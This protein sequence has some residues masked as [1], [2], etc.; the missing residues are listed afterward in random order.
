MFSSLLLATFSV[1]F[2]NEKTKVIFLI[3]SIF[4]TSY[5]LCFRNH[6]GM[7]DGEYMYIF[8]NAKDMRLLDYL[9]Y[10]DIEIGYKIIN[11]I[12]CKLTNNY[13]ICQFIFAFVPVALIEI[14]LWQKREYIDFPIALLYVYMT[15]YY[16]IFAAGLVRIFVSVSIFFYALDYL[17]SGNKAKYTLYVIIASLFHRSVLIMLI[18]L[19]LCVNNNYFWKRIMQFS[20]LLVVS[21]P[22]IMIIVSKYIAPLLGDRYMGY[23]NTVIGDSSIFSF[24]DR[25]TFLVISMFYYN[26]IKN[27]KEEHFNWYQL[28]IVLIVFSIAI[29]IGSYW[30]DL[31]RLVY[32]SN[33]GIILAFSYLIKQSKIRQSG[34]GVVLTIIITIIPY[35]Y[36]MHTVF[37]NEYLWSH[38]RNYD[39]FFTNGNN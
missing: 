35:I 31:G 14:K 30:T 13:N 12:I 21:I 16:F 22:S 20:I 36:L 37:N 29:D 34:N 5:L 4:V 18:L 11:Y 38:L 26:N 1:D 6:T 27:E 39:T 9:K 10:S 3:L 15:L 24:I 25:L 17:I 2:E 7:D 8:F 28:S 32:Y 23:A 33:I 19:L